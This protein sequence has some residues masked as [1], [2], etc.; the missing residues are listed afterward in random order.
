M[1]WLHFHMIYSRSCLQLFQ[2]HMMNIWQINFIMSSIRLQAP[3]STII[4]LRTVIP[5]RNYILSSWKIHINHKVLICYMF[6]QAQEGTEQAAAQQQHSLH[7]HQLQQQR[8][9][10]VCMV[11][12][13]IQAANRQTVYQVCWY[14]IY[15][16]RALSIFYLIFSHLLVLL[17][18]V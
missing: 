4:T 14:S 15:T 18:S 1:P 11:Q 16:I 3:R 6:F 10:Q 5:T 2:I 17:F 7:L 12:I 9:Q 13:P 8:Q